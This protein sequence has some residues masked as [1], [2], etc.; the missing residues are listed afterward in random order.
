MNERLIIISLI[1]STDYIKEI[2]DIW[3]PML[4]ESQMA[5]LLGRWCIEY[6]D[7]Y[8]KAPK[9]N[10]E[11]IYYGKLNE[12]L[13]EDIAEEI[14]EDILPSLN[15]EH[16]NGDNHNLDYLLSGT[17]EYFQARKLLLL[18][19]QVSTTIEKKGSI[20]NNI[21]NAETLL[22][23]HKPVSFEEDESVDLSS[24]NIIEELRIAFEEADV[25]VVTYPKELGQFWNHQF[26]PGAFIS[27][28]ATEKRG[29]TFWLLDIGM[30]ATKQKKKVAFFQAGD[31]NKAEQLKRI[32]VYLC[33][34]SNKEEYCKGHYEAVRDCIRNQMDVCDKGIRE[35]DFGIFEDREVAEIKYLPADT[36]KEAVKDNQDYLPC[37][38]CSEYIEEKLGTPWLKWIK[39]TI[40]IDLNDVIR[41]YQKFF[42]DNNRNFR[43][44]TYPQGTLSVSKIIAKLDMWEDRYDFVP[45]II[46]IDYADILV[47]SVQ[48][49]FRHQQNEIWKE[50]RG[51]SQ[52]KRGGKRPLI[53]SP[54]QANAE[55]YDTMLL[56]LSNFSED[57]RKYG[58]VTAMYGL[59]QSP[60]GREKSLGLMRINELVLREGGFLNTNQVTVIQNLKQGRPFKGS[61]FQK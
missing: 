19:E 3:D 60:D 24:S 36:L 17:I 55:A 15:E 5:K 9:S 28:N 57:K 59:N 38:N 53:I 23:S 2:R 8:K 6:F 22:K 46:L 20:T 11:K 18:G 54:T 29:K 35:C 56:K 37:W 1:T 49:E 21:E 47:P 58:H 30:K 44:A 12:G 13:D 16:I 33:K 10:I 26:V 4:L 41:A 50:L 14:E 25:P 43:L 52:T 34:T 31:M 27:F 40:P 42:I 61:F 48:K 45:D 51:L 7:K 39:E 32:G